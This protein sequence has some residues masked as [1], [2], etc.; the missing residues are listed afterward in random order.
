M[1]PKVKKLLFLQKKAAE[2]TAV[3]VP[4]EV[5]KPVEQVKVEEVKIEEVVVAAVEEV[6]ATVTEE[7]PVLKEEVVVEESA[8][9]TV[10]R[11]ASVKKTK[12]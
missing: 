6:V 8:E 2:K 11:T 7:V 3:V 4:V 5:K 12:K 1:N 9:E 10:V